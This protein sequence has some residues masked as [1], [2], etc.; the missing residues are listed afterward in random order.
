MLDLGLADWEKIDVD[1]VKV[2]PR[3]VF[4]A[5]LDKNL[6]FGDP[7]LA[8][9][10]VVTEGRIKGKK[11][12][13]VSE[14]IDRQDKKTGLTAMMR[15]TAFPVTIIAMMAASGQIEAR[16]VVPQEKA[17]DPVFFEKELAARGI[18]LIHRWHRR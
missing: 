2:A 10:R 6:S 15:C 14:I 11:R 7:D 13:R 1:G 3:S 5:V 17:V 9:I 16:G 18:R 4:K 8:L 12:R